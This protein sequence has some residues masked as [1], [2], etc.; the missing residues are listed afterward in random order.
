MNEDD[1]PDISQLVR[2]Y[3]E[4]R[5]EMEKIATEIYQINS[6][7]IIIRKSLTEK[8]IKSLNFKR[9][10]SIKKIYVLNIQV[11]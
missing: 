8:K 3:M 2:D 6:I 10:S 1:A 4:N 11:F 5:I 9:R 7:Y